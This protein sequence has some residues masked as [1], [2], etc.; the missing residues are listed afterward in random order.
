L[1]PF[2]LQQLQWLERHSLG[3]W[4]IVQLFTILGMYKHRRAL[5]VMLIFLNQLFF[6][7]TCYQQLKFLFI[8]LM[9]FFTCKLVSPNAKLGDNFWCSFS[10][11]MLELLTILWCSTW[12]SSFPSPLSRPLFNILSLAFSHLWT[13]LLSCSSSNLVVETH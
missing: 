9:V 2:Y 5:E 13:L 7:S 3:H 1:L 10:L 6:S 4:T 8:F 12:T 11:L